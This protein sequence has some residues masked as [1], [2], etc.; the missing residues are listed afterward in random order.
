[1]SLSST[2]TKIGGL[3]VALGFFGFGPGSVAVEEIVA[4]VQKKRHDL[5]TKEHDADMDAVRPPGEENESSSTA[6]AVA[7]R[8]HPTDFG[9]PPVILPPRTYTKHMNDHAVPKEVQDYVSHP[10]LPAVK[11]TTNPVTAKFQED[12]NPRSTATTQSPQSSSP[13]SDGSS[14]AKGET[15]PSTASSLNSYWRSFLMPSSDKS[16]KE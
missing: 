10:F 16:G 15:T 6:A 1:M 9:G 4:K 13:S 11:A 5:T 14:T 3:V 2:A 8:R 7:V 12:T